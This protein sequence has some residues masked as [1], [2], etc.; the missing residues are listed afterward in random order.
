MKF[1]TTLAAI[2]ALTKTLSAQTV[3]DHAQLA[4][5]LRNAQIDHRFEMLLPITAIP[6]GAREPVLAN[7]LI[8]EAIRLHDE[9]V[10]RREAIRGGERLA[11]VAEEGAYM[12]QVADALAQDKSFA[13]LPA[14]LLLI[15]A[16]RP[17]VQA[18][19]DFGDPAVPYVLAL[20]IG[21]EPE[22]ESAA[23]LTLEC[24]LTRVT[25]RAPLSASSRSRIVDIARSKLYGVQD[26][27][28]GIPAVRL[29]VATRDPALVK[30]VRQ[31]IADWRIANELGLSDKA[32]GLRFAARKALEDAG[33]H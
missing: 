25:L 31:L 22:E 15:S 23:L 27:G 12:F 4:E 8:E 5:A 16:G 2:A 1:W 32:Y 18:I 3:D 30:R 26:P 7:A 33:L 9:M 20:A 19:A 28:V 6:A 14:L 24:M 21:N 29:A 17:P 10:Q 11:P 13:A